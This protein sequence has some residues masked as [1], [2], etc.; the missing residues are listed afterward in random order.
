MNLSQL[1]SINSCGFFFP[2]IAQDQDG[3]QKRQQRLQAAVEPVDVFAHRLAGWFGWRSPRDG[4]AAKH[5][6]RAHGTFALLD[7]VDA[8]VDGASLLRR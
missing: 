5:V 6:R 3:D 1:Y 7:R 8:R 2:W 4:S